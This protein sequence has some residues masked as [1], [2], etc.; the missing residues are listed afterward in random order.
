[1]RG[2]LSQNDV[3]NRVNVED[4]QAVKKMVLDI[5]GQRYPHYSWVVLERAF[6]D[7]YA[8]FTG[9]YP[10]YLACDTPYHDLRHT[11]DITLAMTR[12]IDGHDKSHGERDRLG[13]ERALLGVITSLF[14]DSGYMRQLGTDTRRYGADTPLP[15]FPVEPPF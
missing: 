15:M 14:H 2:R 7:A 9:Q 12:L 11:M 1:M 10:G 3:S 5:F 8:L 6:D 4:P 13:P